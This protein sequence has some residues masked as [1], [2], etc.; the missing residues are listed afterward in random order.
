MSYYKKYT[1]KEMRK[2]I[3]N[4][5]FLV[6]ETSNED[7]FAISKEDLPDFIM[8]ESERCGHSVDMYVY[9]PGFNFTHIATIYVCFLA[10]TNQKFRADIIE[11]LVKLQTWEIRPRKVKIFDDKKYAQMVKKWKN[12]N[13]YEYMFERFFKKYY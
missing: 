13:Y 2:I 4:K 8:L 6:I 12:F 11:R 1:K 9:V 3:K 7:T 10:E 5:G